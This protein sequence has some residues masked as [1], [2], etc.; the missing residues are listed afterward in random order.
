MQFYV[1]PVWNSL[2]APRDSALIK[3]VP[4]AAK[5]SDKHSPVLLWWCGDAGA[6]YK[7]QGLLTYLF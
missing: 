3:H 4:S 7:C 2:P 1:I 5:N 6:L